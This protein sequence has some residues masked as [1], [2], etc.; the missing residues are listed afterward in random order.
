MARVDAVRSDYSWMRYFT[1]V[2]ND[3][4][5]NMGFILGLLVGSWCSTILVLTIIG[6][7]S[8]EPYEDRYEDFD[9]TK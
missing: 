8:N 2:W 7:A 1:A 5:R 4:R 3:I 9:E 6:G